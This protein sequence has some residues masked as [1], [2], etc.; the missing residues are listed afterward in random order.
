MGPPPEAD[1]APSG[2]S[3]AHAQP[4]LGA[5]LDLNQAENFFEEMVQKTEQKK[6]EET[7]REQKKLLEQEM[8]IANPSKNA[9]MATDW[10]AGPEA[11]IKQSILVGNLTAAV[12][13]C[14]KH[15]KMAE[16]LLL[17]SGGGTTLWTRA[18]DEFLRLQGDSFLSTVGNIM[19]NDFEK[20]VASS[21]VDNWKETLAIIATYSAE[22]YESLCGKLAERLDESFDPRSAMICHICAKN[23]PKTVG[24]WAAT[25]VGSQGSQK[26]ALQDLVEKMT[27]LQEATKFNEPD[28]LFNAKVTQY[29]EILANSG[30]LTAAMRYLTLL[31]DDAS[32]ATLRDRIYNSAPME[33]SQ[34]FGRPPAF[35]FETTD[36]RI[37]HQ[38]PAQQ[39]QQP[40]QQQHMHAPGH[41]GQPAAPKPVMPAAPGPLPPRPA[42]P[43]PGVPASAPA[44]APYAP[45]VPNVAAPSLGP[46]PRL[47]SGG[48]SMPTPNLPTAPS[49]GA[50]PT[51]NAPSPGFAAPA[52]S[53]GA[54]APV[55]NPAT[56]GPPAGP[57][58]ASSA[59]QHS[60]KPVV[61]GTPVPWPLPTSTQQKLSTTSTVAEQNKAVQD[62]SVGAVML[63]D[64]MAPHELSHV[65]GVFGML[66]EMSCQDGNARK[67]E[68]NVKRLE[69]LYNKLQSGHMRNV[70]SQKVL[71]VVK[72]IEAQDYAGA[73]KTMQE[74]S[75]IDWDQN[76]NWIQG[77]RRLIPQK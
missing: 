12:E 5:E 11:I 42:F 63:G 52:P 53:F 71:H 22:Q 73:N 32:S 40:V 67:R 65:K 61:E 62:G 16:A 70:A 15:G 76:K 3:P 49:F 26:L 34:K 57:P 69:D 28:P 35:P 66:L 74:L 14:F 19:T 21:K 51:Y 44:P 7:E 13:C 8:E 33:M 58:R 2:P 43:G 64:P 75:A 17:A 77:V 37:M 50:T 68:D 9:V 4:S 6:Q 30:R 54:P 23:F 72:S 25:H 39:Q 55:Y 1:D 60:A 29:A 31:R 38:A 56:A 24:I 48:P 10:G 59:P 47:P 41:F 27:V 20:L 18:R 36:V 45:S 46:A